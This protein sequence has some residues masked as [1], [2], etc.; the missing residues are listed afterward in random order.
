MATYIT[1]TEA[2]AGRSGSPLTAKAADADSGAAGKGVSG[3]GEVLAP[4]RGRLAIGAGLQVVG[5]AAGLTPY[6]AVAEIAR[7]LLAAGPTDRA[8][9]WWWVLAAVVGLLLRT[10]CAGVAYTITHYA[11]ADTGLLVRRRLAERLGRVPL[12]WFS[13]RGSGRVKRL[14]Q[15]DVHALHHLVA[16]ALND[17]VAA[18]VTPLLA[19]GYLFWVD[20][21]LALLAIAPLPLYVIA[22]GWM[23][24][25]GTAKIAAWSQALDRL[26]SAVVEF[27]AGIAVVKT[28]GQARKAHDRYRRAGDD[29]ADFFGRWVGPMLRVEAASS[30]IIS[31]PVMLLVA[32][33]GGTWFVDEGWSDPVDV[34]PFLML[35]VGLGAPVIALGFGAQAMRQASEAAGRIGEL[36]AEPVLEP[37]AQPGLP[38]GARVR[39]EDVH[40]SYDGENPVLNGVDLVLEQGTVT[41]LIGP[42]GSGKT[43][44]ARLLPRFWDPDRGTVGIGGVDVRDLADRDLYRHV[45]FVFQETRLLRSSVRDN[46][47]LARPDASDAEVEAAAR[48]A[49]I[50]D[51]IG[52]LPRGYHSVVHED[53]H[54]SG[55]ETQRIGI[56]RAIL[57]DTPVLVLDE[58]T[59]FA[60]P[61]S[62]A[63]VQDALSELVAGRTLLVIAHRL[64]TITH[65]DRIAVLEAGRIVESG[66]HTELLA[67]DGT[68][69]RLWRAQSHIGH[70]DRDDSRELGDRGDR[71]GHD[72]QNHSQTHGQ[73]PE[74]HGESTR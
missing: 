60:D 14:L 69:A 5:S 61:E 47:A 36:L 27:V 24:R 49:Q 38:V 30:M 22:Y 31:P 64:H 41:A 21:R 53:A 1:E 10:A 42:S 59:A 6:V 8:T 55:G 16:H 15:D 12:G 3:L 23:M 57:A 56:A 2:P 19:I 67:A 26:D 51:R 74:A 48:A 52:E 28:F 18:L 71:D 58:A 20:W 73:V 63:A 50:H 46:I 66:R 9:V 40:F 7:E 65:V 43:T 29:L 33:G 68:Y 34:L 72:D 45:G 25:D 13:A 4:V 32:L 70:D 62:E 54:L 39:F 17:L 44:L 37:P 35:A 11:D